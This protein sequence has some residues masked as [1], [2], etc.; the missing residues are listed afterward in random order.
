MRPSCRRRTELAPVALALVVTGAALL[1]LQG[2]AHAAKP[3]P[4]A[5]GAG[6]TDPLAA[7]DHAMALYKDGAYADA[8]AAYEAVY[9]AKPLP[10]AMYGIARCHHQLAHYR[11]AANAYEEFLAAAPTHSSAPKAREYLAAT[12]VYLGDEALK[13]GEYEVARR[14]YSRAVELRALSYPA[15]TDD[16]S[17]RLLLGLGEALA[18]AGQR[19][20]AMETLRKAL[21]AALPPEP[22]AKAESLLK[23]LEAGRTPA[24]LAPAATGTMP[25]ESA[26]TPATEPSELVTDPEVPARKGGSKAG[27]FAGVGIGGAVVAAG[28]VVLVVF[29]TRGEAI[30]EGSLPFIDWRQ[31]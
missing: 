26:S 30:P 18:G 1:A 24:G 15:A 14:S 27:L 20:R 9:A 2:A 13:T 12:L 3:A 8:L 25:A 11:E 28:V 4:P 22:R 17:G 6:A 5:P 19:D 16:Y 31:P 7:Y 21:R 29:L 23:D 10:E